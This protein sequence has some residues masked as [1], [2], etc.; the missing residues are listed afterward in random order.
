MNEEPILKVNC[1]KEPDRIFI[2][3]SSRE[4]PELPGTRTGKLSLESSVES[5]GDYIDMKDPFEYK[6][7]SD[8]I[9]MAQSLYS[10]E[11]EKF[12]ES[13]FRY[14]IFVNHIMIYDEEKFESGLRFS[15]I[16]NPG[17]LPERDL[18]NGK[19]VKFA[20]R[21]NDPE[22]KLIVTIGKH[23]KDTNS[24]VYYGVWEIMFGPVV[25]YEFDRIE[26]DKTFYNVIIK[27]SELKLISFTKVSNLPLPEPQPEPEPEPDP[28]EIDK[29]IL[30]KDLTA[31]V[32]DL[33]I[34]VGIYKTSSERCEKEYLI[35]KNNYDNLKKDYDELKEENEKPSFWEWLFGKK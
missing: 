35:L 33:K 11:V 21:F 10:Y 31:L 30:I 32:E 18:S 1:F 25:S 22:I 13:I 5:P 7:Y 6:F 14:R 3:K 28:D 20:M 19:N 9:L 15:E 29:D 27:H 4:L 8:G 2:I 16:K 12:L 23:F 26:N 17:K 34:D 24:N